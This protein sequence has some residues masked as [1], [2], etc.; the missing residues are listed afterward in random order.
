MKTSN[1]IKLIGIS[2]IVL[3]TSGI[4]NNVSSFFMP[5]WIMDTWPEIAHDRLK[6]ME[7]LAYLGILV[8]VIYIIAGIF[9]LLKK[10]FSLILMYAALI[11]SLLYASVP[12]LFYKPDNDLIF[13]M[14]RPIIDLYLLI[15]VYRI[16]MHY[17][18]GPDEVVY[19]FGKI[20][21]S[22]LQLKLLTFLGL[23]C[24]SIPM[25]LIGLWIYVRSLAATHDDAGALFQSYQP[26]CLQGPY[27]NLYLSLIFSV[28]AIFFSSMGLKLSGKL[29]KFLNAII[30]IL[31]SLMFFL[32]L[33][34]LM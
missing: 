13:V 34:Q 19:P 27:A 4:M 20:N 32:Y 24:V 6:L 29:W 26:E 7:R 5:Q 18:K 10:P 16:R 33:F 14:M 31:A 28:L 12:F 17:Y 1:W 15:A 2:C 21:L 9:F 30:L 23:L 25:L 22:P 3:G 8:N 11:I